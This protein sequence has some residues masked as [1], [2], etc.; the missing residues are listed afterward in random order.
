[1][2]LA[3]EE[4]INPS[5][6]PP[7]TFPGT[8]TLITLAPW[9][10]HPIRTYSEM[11]WTGD[12]NRAPGRPTDRLQRQMRV[13]LTLTISLQL[14]DL[15]HSLTNSLADITTHSYAPILSHLHSRSHP[16]ANLNFPRI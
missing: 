16:L 10:Q 4:H 14:V 6:A 3:G 8:V 13:S 5:V 15:N 2:S 7:P 11:P 1:M 9:D 12:T